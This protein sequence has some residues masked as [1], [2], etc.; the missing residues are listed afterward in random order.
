MKKNSDIHLHIISFDIPYPANYGGVIDVFYKAKAL[1]EAGIKIHL[2]CFEE[3]EE[4]PPELQK[5]FYKVDYYR[6][7]MSI[8][9]LFKSNPFIVESRRS[10]QL[11]QNLLLDDYPIL[12]EG[13]HCTAL[14]SDT[15]LH[16]RKR[17]VRTHN[18]EHDYYSNL[19]QAEK[20]PKRKLYFLTEAIKLKK[21]E[22]ILDKA[23]HLFT[24]AQTDQDYFSAK[25]KSA[26]YIPAFHPHK[27]VKSKTGQ[28]AY[29]LYHGNLAVT[30]NRS[31]VTFLAK[32]VFNDL[33]I[34]LKI[35][36]LNPPSSIRGLA[37]ENPSIEIIANPSDQELNELI[38]NAQVNILYTEQATGLK[39]KLLNALYN[40]RF[41]LANE[42]MLRGSGLEKLCMVEDTPLE[43]KKQLKALMEMEFTQ[44]QKVERL[45]FLKGLYDER[46]NVKKIID[47]I[48]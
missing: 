30:E 7:D 17:L 9:K 41:V 32:Q 43:M 8:K 31:A 19:A 40:G 18:I 45:D 5:L 27:N 33:K 36:G 15:R 48:V 26:V 28:G 21:Y 13:L 12:M 23:D 16:Q 1:A 35:A 20:N 29:V 4:R 37:A 3:G 46:K 34:P 22:K 2:H 6:H 24:I 38:Q 47:L 11:I 14:L 42:K 39:L 44:E 10:E 25:Y